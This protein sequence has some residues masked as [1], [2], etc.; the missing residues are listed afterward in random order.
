MKAWQ[1]VGKAEVIHDGWRKVVRQSFVM[2]SGEQFV[3]EISDY[4]GTRGTATIALTDDNQVI[5]ARQFRVGPGQ[6]MDELPGGAVD[7]GEEPVEA[8]VRELREETG[9]QPAQITPLGSIYKHAWM[10]TSWHYFLM[11]GCT[12]HPNGQQLEYGEEIEVVLQPISTFIQNAKQGKM[13]D[14]EAVFLAYDR[15]TERLKE[16]S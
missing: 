9:Y 3:A 2:A 13:T 7:D 4:E 5:I 8:A 1:Q 11:E 6:V 15:L 12:L 14:T 10:H 16:V